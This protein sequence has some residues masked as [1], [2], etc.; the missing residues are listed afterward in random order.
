MTPG[1][2]HRTVK[3]KKGGLIH[4]TLTYP[5]KTST[6]LERVEESPYPWG[7]VA[8]REPISPGP[9]KKPHPVPP[10]PDA[11][12]LSGLSIL[13]RWTGFTLKVDDQ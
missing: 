4:R 11:W 1:H 5:L 10:Q 3:V 2:K 13:H 9:G 6:D 12:Y 7:P 8:K